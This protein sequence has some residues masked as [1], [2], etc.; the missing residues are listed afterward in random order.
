MTYP[1]R[2]FARALFACIAL[3]AAS[4]AF[5]QSAP[6]L[7]SLVIEIWPEYDRPAALVILSGVLAEGVA[8]PATVTLR[9]PV[10]PTAVAY[11]TSANGDLLNLAHE[12]AKSGDY[13][14]VKFQTPERFFHVEFYEP[15]GTGDPARTFRYTWPGDS[16]VGRATVIVQE[17]ATAQNVATEPELKERSTGAGGLTHR[18]GD[19]GALAAGKPLAVTVKYTK[20]DARPSVD[21]KGLRTAQTAPA[22]APPSAAAQAPH[23]APPSSGLPAWALPMAMFGGFAIVAALLVA[24]LWRRRAATPSG[25][26]CTKCGAPL[27]AGDN[28]C[29]KCGA[30]VG[31]ART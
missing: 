3:L 17:P 24:F 4:A 10:A 21:I 12:Q 23:P 6:R 2:R 19:L 29:G 14:L 25:A 13:V 9:L 30:K 22:A 15:M 26:Y 5:A 31:A 18:L 11:A 28:F 20:A 16:A 7:A 8:L 1:L 27:R